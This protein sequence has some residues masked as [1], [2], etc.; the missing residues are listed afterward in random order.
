MS[1]L[2]D[3]LREFEHVSELRGFPAAQS[4]RPGLPRDVVI[5]RVSG[6]VSSPPEEIVDWFVWHDGEIPGPRAYLG[7]SAFRPLTLVEALEN[8][9]RMFELRTHLAPILE[10][11]LSQI[12]T[13]T[14]LAVAWNSSGGTL[15]VELTGPAEGSGPVYAIWPDT[16]E[17]YEVP[18]APSLIATVQLWLYILEV[19][20]A[21]W[22]PDRQFWMGDDLTDVPRGA[23]ASGF[24]EIEPRA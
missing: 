15:D 21:V 1:E 8:V 17:T 13:P 7:P 14:R 3:L 2:S 6:F 4:W 18:A 24:V 16:S 23:Y 22:N 9:P 12:W 20:N 11:D 10:R 5:E 19:S